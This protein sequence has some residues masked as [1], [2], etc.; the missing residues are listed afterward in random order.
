MVPQNIK[1]LA[2]IK[3]MPIFKTPDLCYDIVLGIIDN[4]NKEL[5]YGITVD[6]DVLCDVVDD[7]KPFTIYIVVISLNYSIRSKKLNYFFSLQH[8]CFYI[9]KTTF[10]RRY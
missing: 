5:V 9:L 3:T 7:R 10:C 1:P 4:L 8:I 6:F 2:L